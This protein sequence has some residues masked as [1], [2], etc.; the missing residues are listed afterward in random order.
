MHTCAVPL[1]QLDTRHTLISRT[2]THHLSTCD[3]ETGQAG[4]GR[5]VVLGAPR[6]DFSR[7]KLPGWK[8]RRLRSWSVDVGPR[9]EGCKSQKRGGL[10][11]VPSLG[12]A[13][14]RTGTG[15]LPYQRGSSEIF[16]NVLTSPC[17]RPLHSRTGPGSSLHHLQVLG[18][19]HP[20]LPLLPR[21]SDCGLSLRSH[22]QILSRCET[23]CK[24]MCLFL[25]EMFLV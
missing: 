15:H 8:E 4:A 11:I 2:D 22:R 5:G 1:V 16:H 7:G 10:E 19:H 24:T 17:P 9:C 20:V 18:L 13:G 6:A 14:Q 12:A 3:L 23:W 21:P 25:L